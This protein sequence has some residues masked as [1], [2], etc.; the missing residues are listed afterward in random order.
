MRLD[1]DVTGHKSGDLHLPDMKH[2]C[3]L[4]ALLGGCLTVEDGAVEES[5]ESSDLLF[6]YP[7]DTI[8]TVYL[9]FYVLDASSSACGRAGSDAAI[10]ES[11][12]RANVMYS[13]YFKIHHIHR[14]DAPDLRY[15]NQT[16]LDEYQVFDQI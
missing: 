15:V 9:D 16:P 3:L 4:V 7:T 5:Q 2:L 13:P 6:P 1:R 8:K 10:L 12:R 11:V 14:Y